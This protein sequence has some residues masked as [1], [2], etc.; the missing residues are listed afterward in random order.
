MH[1]ERANLWDWIDFNLDGLVSPAKR[2][3]A[4]SNTRERSY[5]IKDYLE[6]LWAPGF[7]QGMLLP[8]PHLPGFDP[9][10]SLRGC[11]VGSSKSKGSVL[12]FAKQAVVRLCV[13]WGS[14]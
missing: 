7:A 13:Y 14:K 8:Q 11:V 1:Q 6:S 5:L 9:L 4:A 2:T 10:M 3:N 12:V